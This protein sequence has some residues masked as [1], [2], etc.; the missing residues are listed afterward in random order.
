MCLQ[1]ALKAGSKEDGVNVTR[2]PAQP[3]VILTSW[4]YDRA[5][6]GRPEQDGD[7]QP[8]SHTSQCAAPLSLVSQKPGVCL[9]I[10]SL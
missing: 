8:M 2:S 7:L 10:T 1:V 3:S 5:P 6:L 4:M 9:D